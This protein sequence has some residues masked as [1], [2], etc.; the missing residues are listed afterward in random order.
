M[1]I[2]P[3]K[4]LKL[5]AILAALVGVITIWMATRESATL[6][7]SRAIRIGMTQSEV[8]DIMRPSQMV[9]YSRRPR[10]IPNGFGPPTFH[11]EA[12]AINADEIG[13]VIT[14]NGL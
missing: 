9:H 5:V 7:R 14:E 6:R 8:K 3:R 13:L 12:R 11:H 10:P 2:V 1:R 4:R